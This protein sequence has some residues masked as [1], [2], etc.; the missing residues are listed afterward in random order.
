MPTIAQ[1]KKARFDYHILDTFH[2]GLVL[3]GKMVKQLRSKRINIAGKFIVFQN[4]QLK[5]L[6]VGNEHVNEN[7][8]LLLSKKDQLKIQGELSIKGVSCVPLSIF[9]T[10]R[11]IK[12]EIALVKG[13]KDYDK[14]EDKKQQDIQRYVRKFES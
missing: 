8:A 2:A 14:R 6:D 10:R 9:T 13:K 7:V 12:T 3:S 5:I 4:K 1:N 11:W